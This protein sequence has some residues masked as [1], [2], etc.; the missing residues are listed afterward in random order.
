MLKH[1]GGHAYIMTNL[2]PISWSRKPLQVIF[3]CMA[4]LPAY[5]LGH[6]L[7]RLRVRA[8]P[9]STEVL[10]AWTLRCACSCAHRTF[11]DYGQRIRGFDVGW[12]NTSRL[13]G[14]H[15]K[16]VGCFRIIWKQMSPLW[17]VR[18][19]A[20]DTLERYTA[21]NSTFVRLHGKQALFNICAAKTSRVS[22]S[23]GLLTLPLLTSLLL[24]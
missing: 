9:L 15:G 17:G 13:L 14:L 16:R 3:M 7:Q 2:W 19:Q 23:Q 22:R 10:W 24:G 20:C 21:T 12:Q 8:P 4:Q 6:S 1:C 18:R 5:R 11:W